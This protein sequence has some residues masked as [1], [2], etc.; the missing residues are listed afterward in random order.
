M[1]EYTQE[2]FE[3]EIA[4]I[5]EIFTQNYDDIFD[6]DGTKYFLALDYVKERGIDSQNIFALEKLGG[7]LDEKQMFLLR[8]IKECEDASEKQKLK[9]LFS[10]LSD[11]HIGLLSLMINQHEGE[12]L[13]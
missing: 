3:Q 10:Q 12:F 6:P 13:A 9:D 7:E 5:V 2:D 4:E 8:Q 1:K 11:I